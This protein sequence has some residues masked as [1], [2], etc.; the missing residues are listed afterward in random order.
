MPLIL[1][2]GGWIANLPPKNAAQRES[3]ATTNLISAR[4]MATPSLSIQ[5]AHFRLADTEVSFEG[6]FLDR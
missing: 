6:R 3:G 5:S 2:L 1:Q 4:R